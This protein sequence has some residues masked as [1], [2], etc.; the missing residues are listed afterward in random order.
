MPLCLY[1]LSTRGLTTPYTLQARKYTR[2]LLKI[3]W[4]E[5]ALCRDV[6]Q[7]TPVTIRPDEHPKSHFSAP[8]RYV[9]LYNILMGNNLLYSQGH[10]SPAK[11]S[12]T[13]HCTA[14]ILYT[15]WNVQ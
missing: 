12:A 15:S 5:N 1:T 3:I 11:Y 2:Y 7:G 4:D 9:K 13:L 6:P 8:E 14:F 10:F